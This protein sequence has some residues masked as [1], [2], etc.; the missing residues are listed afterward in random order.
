M[1]NTDL[2]D[3]NYVY[4]DK[5]TQSSHPSHNFDLVYYKINSTFI[6]IEKVY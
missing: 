3:T 2:G 1:N 5:S 4:N 6:N